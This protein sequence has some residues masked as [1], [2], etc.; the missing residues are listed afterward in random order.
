MI[1]LTSFIWL[2]VILVLYWVLRPIWNRPTGQT[3]LERI[4]LV[5]RFFKWVSLAAFGFFIFVMTVAILMPEFVMHTTDASGG[6]CIQGPIVRQD[7]RPEVSWLY[8]L[9][10]I[11]LGVFMLRGIGFFYRLFANLEKGILFT[12]ANVECVRRIGW[13]L[14]AL[15]V[16]KAGYQA[17]QM[18]WAASNNLTL[19]ISDLP[20]NLLKGFFVIFIAWIMD[21]GRKI[22]EEQELTV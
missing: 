13:W 2:A 18:I 6:F 17:S 14:V 11:L 16:L 22:Q 3:R 10:W 4:A 12:A 5:A 19:E 1:T 8:T 15:P 21:E 7:F 9:F 20:N